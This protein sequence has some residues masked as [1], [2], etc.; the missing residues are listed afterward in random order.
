MSTKNFYNPSTLPF[1]P[2]SK[3]IL[4]KEPKSLDNFISHILFTVQRFYILLSLNTS[5]LLQIEE[6]KM[7]TF[8]ATPG[9]TLLF[10][11]RS[12]QKISRPAYANS[13]VNFHHFFAMFVRTAFTK[14]KLEASKFK[15]SY[16]VFEQ[17]KKRS[18]IKH[19]KQKKSFNKKIQKS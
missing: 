10:E 1:S 12:S 14:W 5:S 18:R 4:S 7:K 11:N 2:L 17:C 9:S 16:L 3:S 19:K 8:K 6:K 15:K 13:K